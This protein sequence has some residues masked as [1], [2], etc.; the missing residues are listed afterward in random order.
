MLITLMPEF[1]RGL[2]HYRPL[3]NGMILILIILYSPKG[4]W[5]LLGAAREPRKPAA[6]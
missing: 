1:L 3:I 5:D 4:I 6:N 2:G